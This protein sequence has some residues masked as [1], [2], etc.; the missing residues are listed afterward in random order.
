MGQIRKVTTLSNRIPREQ[1]PF[2]LFEC[3]PTPTNFRSCM[4]TSSKKL[5]K[6]FYLCDYDIG[7][8]LL[9]TETKLIYYMK[10]TCLHVS[11]T[12]SIFSE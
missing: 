5:S 11:L 9:L 8:C 1:E 4:M 10:F 7:Q 6:K 3:R 12:F 2:L